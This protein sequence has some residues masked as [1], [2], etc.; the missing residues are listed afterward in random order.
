MGTE[1]YVRYDTYVVSNK[2]NSYRH[3]NVSTN[4]CHDSK[5]E[6]KEICLNRFNILFINISAVKGHVYMFVSR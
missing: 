5:I 3:T 4:K 6:D 2:S 1:K